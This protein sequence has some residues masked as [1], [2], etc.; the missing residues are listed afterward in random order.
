MWWTRCLMLAEDVQSEITNLFWCI[1]IACFSL[2]N[3]WAFF[4]PLVPTSL[5]STLRRR[6]LTSNYIPKAP[7]RIKITL[8]RRSPRQKDKGTQKIQDPMHVKVWHVKGPWLRCLPPP[9]WISSCATI[10]DPLGLISPSH[11]SRNALVCTLTLSQL[12]TVCEPDSARSARTSLT[13]SNGQTRRV[14]L[15][16]TASTSVT[17]YSACFSDNPC[18]SGSLRSLLATLLPPSSLP[19]TLP[20]AQMGSQSLLAG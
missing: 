15:F 11:S 14:H 20:P 9:P 13:T 17:C 18:Q 5:I 2:S 3:Y 8:Y 16:P 4:L 7:H 10:W 19:A 12:A 6:K 1:L